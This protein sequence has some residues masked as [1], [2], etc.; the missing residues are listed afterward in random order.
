MGCCFAAGYKAAIR[1]AD[2]SGVVDD[3]PTPADE[4][5]GFVYEGAAM[6]FALLD[7]IAPWRSRRFASFIAGT[8][9]PHIYM[10]YVGAGWALARTTPRLAWRLGSLDPLLR[11]LMFDGYGFHA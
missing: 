3:F 11:W 1:A 9:G 6:G 10:A 8:A 2:P 7:L 5:T 4:L